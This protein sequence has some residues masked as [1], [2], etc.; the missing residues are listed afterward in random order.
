MDWRSQPGNASCTNASLSSGKFNHA[1]PMQHRIVN[2]DQ[3]QKGLR[4]EGVAEA[5]RRR[6]R[7]TTSGFIGGPFTSLGDNIRTAN[8]ERINGANLVI[9][10]VFVRQRMKHVAHRVQP[11]T[12][13]AI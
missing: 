10:F 8:K 13:L 12:L 4:P 9:V 3:S 11:C 1:N 2:D 7:S 6:I 5:L